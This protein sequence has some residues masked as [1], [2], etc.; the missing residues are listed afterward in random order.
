[1]ITPL[2]A[3][4]LALHIIWLSLCV[5]KVRRRLKVRY[6]DGGEEELQIARTAQSNAVQYIPIALILLLALELNGAS[7]WLICILGLF[8]VVGRFIHAFGILKESLSRRIL[9]MQ[10]T[11][12]TIIGLSAINIGYWFGVSLGLM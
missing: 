11:I 2:F 5:I 4:I 12:T 6:G 9:G 7:A 1:M 10:I 8:L 3:S